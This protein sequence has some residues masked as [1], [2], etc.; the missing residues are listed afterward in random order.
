VQSV[1]LSNI[2]VWV[3]PH[4]LIFCRQL[5]LHLTLTFS[6]RR[7]SLIVLPGRTTVTGVSGT[8]ASFVDIVA[9]VLRTVGMAVEEVSEVRQEGV[10]AQ[11]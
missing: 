6:L 3:P 7:A 5:L 1:L 4:A 9:V 8:C 2:I 11:D 10:L